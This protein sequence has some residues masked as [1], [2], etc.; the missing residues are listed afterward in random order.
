[1]EPQ[2]KDEGDGEQRHT[3]VFNQYYNKA[4]FENIM[5]V[6]LFCPP[7]SRIMHRHA[8]LCIHFPRSL[9][10][11]KTCRE[12]QAQTLFRIMNPPPFSKGAL[13]LTEY[14]TTT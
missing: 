2:S 4:F 13:K 3:S 8:R 5:K 12:L 14:K 9:Y 6:M 1:M 10:L 7:G 11:L